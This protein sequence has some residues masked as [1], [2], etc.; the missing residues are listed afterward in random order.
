MTTTS[1]LQKY[2]IIKSSVFS[3]HGTPCWVSQQWC[4]QCALAVFQHPL[5]YIYIH[6]LGEL[7]QIWELVRFLVQHFNS[8][9]T[10]NTSCNYNFEFSHMTANVR[11]N[12][13]IFSCVVEGKLLA[14]LKVPNLNSASQKMTDLTLRSPISDSHTSDGCHLEK[15]RPSWIFIFNFWIIQKT[16]QILYYGK[17]I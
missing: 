8:N 2:G 12:V 15:W 16:N 9:K 7:L 13:F 11:G 4:R 14:N 5:H 17:H 3:W 1:I 6:N 10:G